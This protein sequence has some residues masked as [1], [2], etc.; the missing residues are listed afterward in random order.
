LHSRNSYIAQGR[1]VV[2]KIRA[3]SGSRP[4]EGNGVEVPEVGKGIVRGGRSKPGQ[5][6]CH[7]AVAAGESVRSD[8]PGIGSHECLD[9][10]I[11]ERAVPN[12]CISMTLAGIV[13]R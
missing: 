10:G 8:T 7:E 6:D 11:P 1:G 12:G 13:H 4:A 5:A 3:R 9:S 2:E